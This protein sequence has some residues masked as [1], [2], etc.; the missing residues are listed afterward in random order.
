M[1]KL[2]VFD[3][4]GT[5]FTAQTIPFF[6]DQWEELGYPKMPIR[7]AKS[8]IIKIY[9]LN[10]FKLMSTDKFRARAV[11]DF[12]VAFNNMYVEDI[13]EF[14]HKASQNATKYLRQIVID[15]I[16]KMKSENYHTVLLSGCYEGFLKH[17][18][19]DLDIDTIIGSK[20]NYNEYFKVDAKNP[21]EVLGGFNKLK[22]I[23]DHFSNQIDYKESYAY[24][25]SHTDAELLEAFG[26]PVAVF[27]NDRL[28]AIAKD[29]NYRVID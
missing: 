26:N 14:F 27:P 24:A 11:S 21:A 23:S 2:A 9:L 22:K 18:A 15:E 12:L 6:I 5:L 13:D 16:T 1:Q 4:D 17:I 28:L 7:S 25:D 8:K 29:K 10:K 19:E 3:F 20:I